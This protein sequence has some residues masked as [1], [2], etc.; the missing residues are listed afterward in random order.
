MKTECSYKDS[1]RPAP[2]AVQSV[3]FQPKKRAKGNRTIH[4]H[5]TVPHDPSLPQDVG[6]K[7]T[8][9]WKRRID[10]NHKR[11]EEPAED[12]Y[13]YAELQMDLAEI[14]DDDEQEQ[15][16]DSFFGQPE[17]APVGIKRQ[18]SKDMANIGMPT[19]KGLRES[20]IARADELRLMQGRS[21]EV[22]PNVPGADK[23]K[24]KRI[25]LQGDDAITRLI[26]AGRE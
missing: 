26:N 6:P 5:G 18:R 8:E 9:D 14:I 25:K 23:R 22:Q 15:Q 7:I 3:N 17:G 19:R 11:G 24:R 21:L 20:L 4:A 12:D 13:S 16:R 2:E 1:E 10:E